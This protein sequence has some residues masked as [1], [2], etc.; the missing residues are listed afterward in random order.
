VTPIDG[1]P[2]IVDAHIA[3]GEPTTVK[4]RLTGKGPG[5]VLHYKVSGD[6]ADS[7]V[8][9]ERAAKIDNTVVAKVGKA[10]GAR[11]TIAFRTADVGPAKHIIVARVTKQGQELPAETVA[12]FTAAPVKPRVAK[13]LRIKVNRRR[14]FATVTSAKDPAAVRYEVTLRTTSGRRLN[15]TL[16]T[17]K[18]TVL[19]VYTGDKITVTV[20]GVAAFQRKGAGKTVSVKIAKSEKKKARRKK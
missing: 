15:L 18:F 11:G 19:S 8:F 12:R 14:T 7:V 2:K 5:R 16:A 13:K 10:G 1:A 17:P 4:A 6:K 3:Y 9:E 20:R